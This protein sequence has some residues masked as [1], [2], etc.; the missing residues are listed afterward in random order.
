MMEAAQG[1][2]SSSSRVAKV[3]WGGAQAQNRVREGTGRA[4]R[5]HGGEGE[6]QSPAVPCNAPA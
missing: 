6:G 1:C 5:A 3:G 4:V 2:P